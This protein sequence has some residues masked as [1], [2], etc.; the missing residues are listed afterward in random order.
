[1]IEELQG[2]KIIDVKC[3]ARHTLFIND[4]CEVYSCGDGEAG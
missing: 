2:A 1:M 4:N 3:G